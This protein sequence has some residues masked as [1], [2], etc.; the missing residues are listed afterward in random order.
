LLFAA[1]I[2]AP[3]GCAS[4]GRRG[5]TPEDVAAGRELTQQGAAAIELGQW[6]RAELLL[7]RAAETSPVD[8]VTRRQL[9]EALWH[10]N[11]SEAALAQMEAAVQL[12]ATDA[13]LVVRRGEMLLAT[14]AAGKALGEAE[15][16][17]RLD[18]KLSSAWALRGR[19]NWQLQQSDRALADLQR[20]LQY[21]PESSDVLM[22][23]AA[24]YRQR[25]EHQRCL[26]TLH[27]LLDTYPPGQQAQQALWMEGLA[28]VDLGRSQ[29]A[30]ES[31]LAATRQG[32]PNADLLCQLA[33]AQLASGRRQDAAETLRQALLANAAHGPSRQLQIQ[34]ASEPTDDKLLR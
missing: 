12:D 22:D 29:Q 26:T 14:G 7:Q 11:A 21:S 23:V 15:Q 32:P 20:A 8:A 25:G 17:I 1:T 6:E 30:A 34:L 24:I 10:R 31:L 18:P 16:A 4:L 2:A 9:A 13:S 19:V 3:S 27:H 33:Q 5:P 28:L